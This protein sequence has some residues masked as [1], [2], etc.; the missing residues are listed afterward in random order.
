[1]D[2]KYS[3]RTILLP[4]AELYKNHR[5]N[6]CSFLKNK[7]KDKG[8]PETLINQAYER[9]LQEGLPKIEKEAFNQTVRFTT[10]FHYDHKKDWIHF[11]KHWPILLEDPHLKHLLP[12]QPRVTYRKASNLKNKIT[13]VNWNLYT[14]TLSTNMSNTIERYVSMWKKH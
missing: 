6:K 12:N 9:Y 2:K 3:Q 10:R 4:Q 14:G 5:L 7:L 11:Q 13:P 8:Y 1:M